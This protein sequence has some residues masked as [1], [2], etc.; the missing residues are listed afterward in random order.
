MGFNSSGLITRGL[1]KAQKLITRG[2][3]FARKVIKDFPP[4]VDVVKEYIFE[5]NSPVI[6]KGFIEINI[7]VPVKIVASK[8][9]CLKSNVNKEIIKSLEVVIKTDSKKLFNILDAI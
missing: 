1:G 6:K 5:I 7:V 2:F 9:F 3:G 4:K 8:C